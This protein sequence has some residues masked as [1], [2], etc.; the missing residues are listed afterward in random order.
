MT[1]HTIL[2]VLHVLGASLVLGSVVFA[3][4]FLLRRPFLDV[5]RQWMVFAWYVAEVAIGAQLVTGLYLFLSERSEF[6][7]N[8]LFWT[9]L[10]LYILAGAISGGYIKRQLQ[11]L[12]AANEEQPTQPK[13]LIIPMWLVVA[14][15]V[16]IITVAVTM[17]EGLGT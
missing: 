15:V 3:L 8:H 10:T 4:F 9:K 2:L 1:L 5:S 6:E 13:G 11:H 14:M 12:D 7:N 16:G 17:V